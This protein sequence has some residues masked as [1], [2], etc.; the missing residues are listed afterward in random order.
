MTLL[1]IQRGIRGDDFVLYMERFIKY[2]RIMIDKPLSFVLN[3]QK[4]HLAFKK[5]VT[6]LAKENAMVIQ[7][8]HHTSLKLQS[9]D[10]SIYGSYRKFVNSSSDTCT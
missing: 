2:I 8:P 6:G 5:K 4:P 3:N 10:R 9:L 1:G 7:F